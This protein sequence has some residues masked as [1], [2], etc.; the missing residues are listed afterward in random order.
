MTVAGIKAEIN[1]NTIVAIV[2][3]LMTFAGIVTVWNQVQY[4]QGD[5]DKWITQHED[6][7]KQIALDLQSL[8]GVD[9]DRGGKMIDMA[10]REGQLEK[11]VDALDQRISRITESYGNQFTDI[12]NSLGTISTQLALTNQTLGEF[13]ASRGLTSDGK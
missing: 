11:T 4:K 5:V 13:K 6:L 9:A 3:F 8:H 7:H 10:F 1:L 2:G 12:R